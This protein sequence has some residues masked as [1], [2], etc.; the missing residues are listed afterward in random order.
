V[1]QVDEKEINNYIFHTSKV[2]VDIRIAPQYF[3]LVRKVNFYSY[4]TVCIEFT[5]YN[6]EAERGFLFCCTFPSLE[7]AISSIEDYL[8]SPVNNWVNHTRTG[9]Y[10]E[11]PDHNF[12]G[13]YLQGEKDL[14]RDIFNHQVSLPEI[15]DFK[16]KDELPYQSFDAYLKIRRQIESEIPPIED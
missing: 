9:D 6:I 16:L 2:C 4:H 14:I 15:G 10:P 3:G 1:T 11:L 13:A 12:A 8:D 7:Q 5:E